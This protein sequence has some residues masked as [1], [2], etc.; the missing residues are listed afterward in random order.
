MY[1]RLSDYYQSWFL[2]TRIRL[3]IVRAIVKYGL[4]NF[5][6]VILEYTY[7]ENLITCEQKWIDLL[8]PEYNLNT[9]AGNSKGYIHTTEN[10]EK[11]H[12]AAIGRKHSESVKKSMSESRLGINNT[13][14]GKKHTEETK[15]YMKK[16]RST[17]VKVTDLKNNKI[18]VYDTRVKAAQ[19]LGVSRR[20]LSDKFK[21]KESFVIKDE[22]LVELIKK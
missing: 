7:S 20:L 16:S 9:S 18:S 21:T 19:A 5:T 11:M 4:N 1:V 13:F 14:F 8:K 22:Y 15:E 17:A 12:T 6:L 10:L 2:S 3:Y